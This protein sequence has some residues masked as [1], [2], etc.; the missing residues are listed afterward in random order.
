ML[1]E[2][3][4][5]LYRS[6]R[7]EWA[8]TQLWIMKIERNAETWGNAS[9]F[10]DRVLKMTSR[11]LLSRFYVAENSGV[12]KITREERCK[13]LVYWHQA[14][15]R[16]TSLQLKNFTSRKPSTTKMI[17]C[18]FRKTTNDARIYDDLGRST[19]PERLSF[20][21]S[22]HMIFKTITANLSRPTPLSKCTIK[23]EVGLWSAFSSF[24]PYQ[25]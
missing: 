18:A 23:F 16:P 22:R 21:H 5:T 4:V 9:S 14:G 25:R 2:K 19:A 12:D 7:K 15:T 13:Y 8:Q 6:R 17:K 11:H 10:I 20:A 3:G 1:K 24:V